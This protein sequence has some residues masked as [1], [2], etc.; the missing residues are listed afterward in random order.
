MLHD[1]RDEMRSA[2][3]F[4]FFF[5]TLPTNPT[6]VFVFLS[7][8][9]CHFA[10]IYAFVYIS[11]DQSRLPVNKYI[12][13]SSDCLNACE[14]FFCLFKIALLPTHNI[15]LF[16]WIESWIALLSLIDS[17]HFKYFSIF[18]YLLNNLFLIQLPD[19]TEILLVLIHWIVNCVRSTRLWQA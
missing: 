4:R 1:A 16:L 8:W 18:V 6:L 19:L 14:I 10:T 11:V 12:P 15:C 13:G 5:L 9:V 17:F 3:Y 2:Y 7:Y